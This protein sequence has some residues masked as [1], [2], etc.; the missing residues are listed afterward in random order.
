[1]LEDVLKSVK[2]AEA[3]AA[4]T[5]AAAEE[6]AARL[7]RQGQQQVAADWQEAKAR[8][9]AQRATCMDEAESH[10]TAAATHIASEYAEQCAALHAQGLTKVNGLVDYLTEII[11]NGSC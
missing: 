9:R 4:Q 8:A 11:F 3:Q 6:N 5:V 10:A 1:M 2:E 7:V